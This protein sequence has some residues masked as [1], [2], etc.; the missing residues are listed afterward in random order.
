MKQIMISI[1]LLSF[2]T[3]SGQIGI[4]GGL[5]YSSVSV[6]PDGVDF[7]NDSKIGYHLGLQGELSI[8][9]ITL[10]PALLYHLKGAKEED[11]GTL[12]NT[13]LHYLEL[14][15]NLAI[16]IGTQR[17]ALVLEAG[18]YFGYLLDT[19]SEF[20]ENIGNRVNRTDW[21]INFGAVIEINGLGIGANYSNGLSNIAKQDQVGQAFK[22]TNGNL[23]LFGYLYF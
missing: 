8:A 10:R 18:P 13:N 1:A 14:P 15:I 17:T 21:G 23:A 4:R 2:A 12:G 3:L 16:R 22:T 19:S 6:D 20:I 5:N 11:A 9:G 7:G